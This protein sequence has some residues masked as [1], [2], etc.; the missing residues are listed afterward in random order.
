VFYGLRLGHVRRHFVRAILEGIA[1]LYPG[2]AAIVQRHGLPIG[3]LTMVDG[4]ARSAAWNQVKADVM[5]RPIRTTR[6][7]EGGA[8]GAAMLAGLAAGEFATA[9]V[10]VAALVEAADTFDPDAAVHARYAEL[11]ATWERVRTGLFSV[12]GRAGS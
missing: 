4:E 7:A 3:S 1:Y 11:Y 2:F 8:L 12:F 10:A 9:E 5:G 6:V